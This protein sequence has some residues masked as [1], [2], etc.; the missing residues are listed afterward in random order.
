MLSI[1]TCIEAGADSGPNY[2]GDS[3]AYLM[4]FATL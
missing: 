1:L 3:S 4:F 2:G